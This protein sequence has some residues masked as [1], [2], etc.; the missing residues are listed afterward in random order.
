MSLIFRAHVLQ[1]M[2]ERGFNVDDVEHVL[3]EG[4]NIEEYPDDY[5]LPSRLMLGF[6]KDRPIHLVVAD[7]VL[8]DQTIIITI[9]EPNPIEW[10]EGFTKRK[11]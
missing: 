4:A 3:A 1:R 8:G 10:A 11:S 7:N 9:Y 6:T 2:F 5:P